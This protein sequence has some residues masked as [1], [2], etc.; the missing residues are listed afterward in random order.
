MSLI[1]RYHPAMR[2]LLIALLM[3]P[4]AVHAAPPQLRIGTVTIAAADIADARAYP[5]L[6]G[7]VAMLV[8]LEPAALK[9]LASDTPI[10]FSI[11]GRPLCSP[12]S[13]LL[14]GDG[15]LLLSCFA[16]RPAAEVAAL[17]K[18]LSG[19]DPLPETLDDEP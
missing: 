6:E 4:T 9:R 1:A 5:Q 8:T 7:D 19:K 16:K 13:A 18:A 11:D 3:I 2:T 15:A 12:G 10:Q 14:G 17:A